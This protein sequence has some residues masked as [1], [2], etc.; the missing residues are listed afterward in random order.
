MFDCFGAGQKV[1]R[2]TFAGRSWRNDPQTRDDMFRAFPIV[3]RLHELLWYLDQAIS[4][5][6][7]SGDPATVLS[8]F[9]HVRE[10]SNQQPDQLAALDVDAEYDA[11]RPL[12]VEASDRARRG[13]D[14][15]RRKKH[16]QRQLGPGSDLV[17]ANLAKTDLRGLSLRGC[18]LI[19][20]D[21]SAARLSQCDVLGVDM[22]DANLSG[23]DLDGVIYLTQMQVNRARGDD[24]TVLPV[25]FSRPAHWSAR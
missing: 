4:L 18:L 15:P 19:S 3:R 17:G 25:G 22:R 8:R 24:A 6:R 7:G 14:A 12:L 1:S 5:I 2:H 9:E 20:A 13:V 23:A 16:G 11:A 10:L 21:L